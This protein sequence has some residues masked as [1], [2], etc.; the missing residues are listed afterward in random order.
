M[1]KSAKSRLAA[2]KQRDKWR[3]KR[4]YTVRAPR[5]P[6]SYRNIGETIAEED[7]MLEGRIYEM[8]QNELDGDFSKMHVKVKFRITHTVGS[9]AITEFI[10]HEVAKDHIRRQVRRARSKVDDTVDIVTEDGFYVRLKPLVITHR[11]AKSSQKQEIRSRAK[12]II[13]K[14]GATSTWVGIQKSIMDGSLESSIKDAVS[15]IHPVRT[16]LLR[17]TQLI[18]SGVTVDD[19]PTLE[20][21][22]AEEESEKSTPAQEDS[23]EESHENDDD[24]EIDVEASEDVEV[25]EAESEEKGDDDVPDY[26]SLKVAELKELLKAAG[27]PVS[28]K[29][30]ELIA[31]LME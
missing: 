10:G 4:W 28:G 26:A 25:Q 18:Q 2:R 1:A 21:I 20:E 8:M 17:K 5:N 14:A 6:W 15:A 12:E 22:R 24:Q 13:L 27:K 29:K 16:V 19:G 9:D 23:E 30:A 11:T 7:S 31:R 3:A